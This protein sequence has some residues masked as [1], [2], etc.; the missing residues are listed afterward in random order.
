MSAL[1]SVIGWIAP[2]GC[3]ICQSEGSALCPECADDEIIPYGGRCF[4]CGVISPDGRTCGHC[5]PGAPRHVWVTTNYENAARELLKVYKF[6]HQRAAADPLTGLM[7]AT[8]HDFLSPEDIQQL[9][10]LVVPVPTASSRIRQRSFDHSALLARQIAR[11]LKLK[12][13]NALARLGQSRQLGAARSVR[14]RQPDGKYVARYP[15][16]LIGENILLIDDVVTTGATLRAATKALR[17][18]GA[19]RVDALIFAKRL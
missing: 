18:S 19:A 16:L 17:S 2:P 5:R 15:N 4:G 11:R 1:D 9:R 10:Y 8:L 14:L 13:I 3:V 12:N 6:G 7:V